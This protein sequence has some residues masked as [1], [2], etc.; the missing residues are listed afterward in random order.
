[1]PTLTAVSAS[2]LLSIAAT[3]HGNDTDAILFLK[4]GTTMGKTLGLFGVPEAGSAKQWLGDHIDWIQ[5]A[6]HTAWGVFS[7]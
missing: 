5:A 3:C 1:M 4:Q 7:C 6:S 2:Q